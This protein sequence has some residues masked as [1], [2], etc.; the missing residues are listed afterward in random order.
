MNK[1]KS[2]LSKDC[3]V[4]DIFKINKKWRLEFFFKR[5]WHLKVL[6]G[7]VKPLSVYDSNTVPFSSKAQYRLLLRISDEVSFL[8]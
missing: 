1:K 6:N 3:K 4:K 8:V 2:K 5:R 7:N